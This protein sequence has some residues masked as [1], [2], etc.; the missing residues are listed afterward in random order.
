MLDAKPLDD[1]VCESSKQR[2]RIGTV[3]DCTTVNIGRGL[4]LDCDNNRTS[5]NTGIVHYNQNFSS[6]LSNHLHDIIDI[7][8]I[9]QNDNCN[10]IDYNCTSSSSQCTN[11]N[12]HATMSSL[13][14][15]IPLY[16]NTKN[17]RHS[18][19]ICGANVATTN[20]TII[21]TIENRHHQLTIVSCCWSFLFFFFFFFLFSFIY[22]LVFMFLTF[23]FYQLFISFFK[24]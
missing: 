12:Q 7:D 2:T 10:R 5:I 3:E 8:I 20:H 15:Q 1:L 19:V 21:K 17:C 22:S 4:H 18:N 14:I 13:A 6:I 16:N 9:V 11:S 23:R 24:L